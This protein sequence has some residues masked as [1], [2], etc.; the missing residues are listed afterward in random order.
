M[1]WDCR[2]VRTKECKA[3][4]ITAVPNSNQQVIVLEGPSQ[5]RHE[6]ALN[7]EELAADVAGTRKTDKDGPEEAVAASPG[8]Y[9]RRSTGI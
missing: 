4:A 3:R 9:S 7:Q 5:S 2:R 1:Y 8:A 6:H